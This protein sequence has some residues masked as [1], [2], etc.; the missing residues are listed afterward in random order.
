M[1]LDIALEPGNTPEEVIELGLLAE[2]YGVTTIWI[3]NDPSARDVFLCMAG[4]ARV[5]RRIRL[6]V[7]AVSPFEM[8]PLKMANS[9]LALNEMSGG[10]ASIVVGGGGAFL[11]ATSFKPERRVRAVAECIEILKKASAAQPL[12]YQGELYTV[13]NYHPEWALR[14]RP[15]ILAGA[16][17]P[18]MLRMAAR[19]ADGVLM[20]DIPLSLCGPAIQ[21][22][23]EALTGNG[24][25]PDPF[26][27]NNYW[28][29]HVKADRQA[30]VNEARSRLV[31]RGMLT[32]AYLAPFLSE[33][34][35]DLVAAGMP[36]FYKAFA[37]LSPVIEG[38]PERIIETLIDNLTLTADVRELDSRIDV[39]RKFA[40]S[41]FTRMTLG[42]HGDPATAIRLIGERVIPALK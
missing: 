15:R 19:T 6:G 9:L 16:N 40:A 1:Q 4:L 28:A 5:S 39:L 8:H 12:T 13:R 36:A 34:D 7:M 35:C 20:S 25:K 37:A 42:L 29:W 30:A 38:V 11:S 26:E 22:V 18:Q 23:T 31:L 14:E 24:G 2:R 32:K 3:T 27:L 41:G 10:R 33:A 17:K 21:T